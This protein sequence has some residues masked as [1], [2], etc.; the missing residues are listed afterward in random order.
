MKTI[1]AKLRSN[2]GSS[3]V[4]ALLLMLV[5]IMVSHTILAAAATAGRNVQLGDDGQQAYLTVSSAA[6]TFRDAALSFSGKYRRTTTQRFAS[7]VD[8]Q[9]NKPKSTEVTYTNLESHTAFSGEIEAAIRY[10]IGFPDTTYTHSYQIQAQDYA[11]V[12][13]ELTLGKNPKVPGQYVLT[14]FFS[15]VIPGKALPDN[16]CKITVTMAAVP[17]TVENETTSNPSELWK[18]TNVTW[19]FSNPQLTRTKEAGNG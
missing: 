16:P 8:F 11:P 13:M 2:R 5:A 12:D 7:L 6:E 15:N 10:A 1:S 18:R 4:M 14:A 19:D 17:R 3:M 9:N